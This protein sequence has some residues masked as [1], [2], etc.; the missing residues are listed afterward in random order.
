MF[1]TVF[2]LTQYLQSVLGYSALEAGVRVA[3]GRRRASCS[4][5]RARRGWPSALG[6]KVVVAAGLD[7]DRQRRW[8]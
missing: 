8:R 6:T 1:G 4:A 3:A 7:A 5:A 2:F